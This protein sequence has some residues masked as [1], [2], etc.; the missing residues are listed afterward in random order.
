MLEGIVVLDLSRV[1]A[2]PYATQ[3]LADLGARVIKVEAPSGDDTR[4]WGPPFVGDQ[5]TYFLSVNR[6]KESVAIDLK[7]PDGPMLVRRL[8]E[9]AD[10]LVENFKVGDLERYGLGPADLADVNPA[11]VYA[12]IRAYGDDGPRAREPGYD[13]ALQAITGLMAMTGEVDGGPVKL[14]VAWIDVLTGLHAATAILAALHERARTGEGKHL[15]LSLFEVGLASLVNQAQAALVTGI[16]PRRLGSAHPS[17]VPYQAFETMDGPL[18]LA[19]GNDAQFARVADVVGAPEWASDPRFATNAARVAHRETLIADLERRLATRPRGEWLDAF[20]HA[21]VAA[22]PVYDLPDA[23]RD[24]QAVALGTVGTYDHPT[25]GTVP[26][27]RSPL[28][29]HG[30]LLRST[31]THPGDDPGSVAE[32]VAAGASPDAPPPRLGEDSVAVLRDLLGVDA[33]ELEGYV[34]SGSV[35]PASPSGS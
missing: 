8:A 1:L 27:V 9:R 30:P 25:V 12:S 20:S 34:A 6:G 15:R 2:G 31:V 33:T 11:M 5:S 13:A 17:I 3:V 29:H 18:M 19:V 26:Y 10:V 32:T 21:S 23:L 7:S 4:S 24:P 16:A 14:G 28:R 35:V 22:T